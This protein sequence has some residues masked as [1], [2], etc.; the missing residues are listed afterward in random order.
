MTFARA[1]I[2]LLPVAASMK[3]RVI[4]KNFTQFIEFTNFSYILTSPIFL[5]SRT[6]GF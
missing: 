1:V 6:R 2:A 4:Y 5:E 3:S